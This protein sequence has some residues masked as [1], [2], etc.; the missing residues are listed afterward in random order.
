MRQEQSPR[1]RCR[2]NEVIIYRN[3]T[4]HMHG[5]FLKRPLNKWL[6]GV[7]DNGTCEEPPVCFVKAG[8]YEFTIHADTI[9]FRDHTQLQKF[10]NEMVRRINEQSK[11][12]R[13]LTESKEYQRQETR[14]LWDA[15]K[16][17]QAQ[18]RTDGDRTTSIHR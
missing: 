17:L 6:W 18:G 2:N 1:S 3:G 13:E 10:L 8:E 15:V 7:G 16:Q 12:I 4:I 9:T 11:R 5:K 14:A